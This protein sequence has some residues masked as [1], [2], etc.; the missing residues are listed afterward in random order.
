MT[1]NNPLFVDSTKLPGD[2]IPCHVEL[3]KILLL[4]GEHLSL[5][6]LNHEGQL[7][8]KEMEPSEQ[9]CFE[10]RLHLNHQTQIHYQ[11]VIEDENKEEIFKS[12]VY[13][14]RAQYALVE[15]WE[16]CADKPS[17]PTMNSPK[18]EPTLSGSTWRR[19]PTPSY[20]ELM[21]KW[22]F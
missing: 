17:L 12:Q 9:N 5:H 20:R 18:T 4:D 11:F 10:T 19:E 14:E 15:D 3:K 7:I 16:P 1:K 2:L 6:L 21:E 8:K 22:G 13:T